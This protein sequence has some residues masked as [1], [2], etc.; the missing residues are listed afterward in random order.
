MQKSGDVTDYASSF[1]SY[2][3]TEKRV[4]QN[5][6]LAYKRDIEQFYQFLKNKR[7]SVQNCKLEHLKNFLKWLK[8]NGLAAKSLSRKIT[9]LKL[10]YSFLNKRHNVENFAD[11]LIFPK[12]EQTLP[13][14]LSEQEIQQ[15]LLTAD[16][17]ISLKGQRN[18]VMI[19]LLYATGM[20]V[21]ELVNLTFDQIHFDTGFINLI[22]KGNK[23]RS[24]PLPK[25]IFKLLRHYQENIYP[26]LL[27]KEMLISHKLIN[28]VF[29]STQ[30]NAVKPISRQMFWMALKKVLVKASIFKNISPH[31]LRHSLATHLLKN[32]ADVRSLQ[33]I[34]GHENLSTVQIYTHL[35]DPQVR[36][37]YD[38]KHPRA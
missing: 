7:L 22:G 23:E 1:C 36:K 27:S 12:V 26:K 4:L 18:K 38:K 17:D 5:T 29:V 28:Y 34:L 2:L 16:K 32:G 30:N 11:S 9:S 13:N 24:I 3:L 15:L 8:T 20:R 14:Y 25:N 35:E 10:F 37:I 6:Y 33:L 21:S 31:S 19:Y